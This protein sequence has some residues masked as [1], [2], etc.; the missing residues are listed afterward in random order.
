MQ[1]AGLWPVVLNVLNSYSLIITKEGD[2]MEIG[3]K[4]KDLRIA[5]GLTQE[6]LAD[7]SELSK[8]FISQLERDLTSPSI[9][10]LADILQVLGSS[11]NEFFYEAPE[12]QIVFKAEDYFVK[13]DPELNNTIEWI[14]PNAQKNIMEPIRLTLGPGGTTY[15]DLPH[16]GEEFGYILTGVV[17]IHI[18]NKSYKVKKGETFYLIPNKSHSLE[19]TGKTP[20]QVLWISSPPSF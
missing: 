1:C 4:I 7:R 12:E 14:V 19:N 11:L 13:S 9:A 8:G 16:E 17:T 18:G 2:Y 5:K 10:T 3:R 15:M 6:E 20:A